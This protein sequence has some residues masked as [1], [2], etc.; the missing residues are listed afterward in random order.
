MNLA[1]AF[2]VFLCGLGYLYYTY[3]TLPQLITVQDYKPLL[4]SDVYARGGEKI[5]ELYSS[6]QGVR[7]LVNYNDIPP[8]LTKAFLAAEDDSFFEHK[9]FN[10]TAILRAVWINAIS[11]KKSQGASTITQQTARTLFL[12]SEK[13]YI[14]K[15]KEALLTYKMEK[16]LSKEDILY[17]YLNQIYLGQGAYG[18]AAAAETYF[19]KELKDLT[20]AEMALL[21]GVPTSPSRF[22]PVVNPKRAKERQLYVLSRM[23]TEG[24]A[25]EEETKKAGQEVLKIQAKKVYKDTGPYFVETVRQLLVKELGEEM[26]LEQGLKIYTSLD[27]KAQIK[28]IESVNAGLRVIDKRRGYRGA[29][30]QINLQDTEA[31]EKFLSDTREKLIREKNSTLY[32]KPDGTLVTF[33]PFAEIKKK[34]KEVKNIPPYIKLNEIV[35]GVVTKIEDTLGLVYV[36]F[37]ES[38]GILPLSE[39]LWAR[40]FNPDL[41]YGEHLNIKRPS[42][43]L[44][45][46]DVIDVK[47]IGNVFTP[48]KPAAKS[49]TP[50]PSYKDFASL[51]LEQEPE[52]QGA[53]LSFDLESGDITAMIGGLDYSKFKFNRAYQALRQTGSAFKPIVYAAGLEQGLTVA[54]PIMGAPIVYGAKTDEEKEA[55]KTANKK[56]TEQ[57]SD[58]AWKPENYDGKFTGDVLMRTALKRSLNTPTIRVLEKATIPY[59][60]A[61]ARRLGLFSP[62]NMDMSLALGSS[63][64]SLYEMNKAMAIFAKNGK[65][66]SPILVKEVKNKDGE[67]ILQNISLDQRF[68]EKLD[69]LENEFADRRVE[70]KKALAAF[71]QKIASAKNT[72]DPDDEKKEKPPVNGFFFENPDQLISP[73]TAYLVTNML[74]G[75]ATEPDGTGGRA[76]ALGRPVAGKTG[77]TNGYYDAWF[78]GYT[79][80]VATSVWVGLDTE[81]TLGKGQTG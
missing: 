29:K 20:L 15:I 65:R 27:L 24:F 63:G 73:Q 18:I 31:L 40:P 71:Q 12:S 41:H 56:L 9:G 35:E 45:V 13:T 69:A 34:S 52:V 19:R 80:Q 44:K 81:K 11:G 46:G 50:P 74:Q 23:T 22:N 67:S 53:L 33:E 30:T 8:L 26:L 32:L 76:A 70:Y 66:F 7:I 61:Y 79:P 62:L 3:S 77:T 25:T 59:A 72:E 42:Q 39:M 68:K 49:K 28:A 14:R 43:A 58:E 37:A 4:S 16:N 48:V 36:R 10:L 5:G 17:L 57:E 21:A 78:L 2:V 55:A 47:I 75:V 51:S 54:T 6:K 64:V 38:Q 1:L 60:A